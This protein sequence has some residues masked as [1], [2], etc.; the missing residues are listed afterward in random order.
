M[1]NIVKQTPYGNVWKQNVNMHKF[2]YDAYQVFELRNSNFVK[3]ERQVDI[4]DLI[5]PYL[6]VAHSRLSTCHGL[7]SDVK[8]V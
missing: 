7:P 1:D 3:S 8:K 4:V 2:Y 6:S 5:K